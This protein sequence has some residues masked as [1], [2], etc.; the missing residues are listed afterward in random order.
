[1]SM[2]GRRSRPPIHVNGWSEVC[3][4]QATQLGWG[5]CV[6]VCVCVFIP[7]CPVKSKLK[8]SL[9]LVWL[10]QSRCGLNE[11]IGSDSLSKLNY[12]C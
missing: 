1:M 9:L 10:E 8:E 2:G 4:L 5:G 7:Q 3:L 6:C 11:L 12:V